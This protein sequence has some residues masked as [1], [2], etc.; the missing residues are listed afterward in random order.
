MTTVE[1]TKTVVL[2]VIGGLLTALLIWGLD[3]LMILPVALV[4]GLVISVGVL[5]FIDWRL[6]L[7]EV[8]DAAP[9]AES[10][11]LDLYKRELTSQERLLY[12]PIFQLEKMFPH[13]LARPVRKGAGEDT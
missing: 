6:G 9:E 5:K 7:R 8:I 1:R 12:Q 10:V 3:Q 13:L 4:V 11:D 2:A